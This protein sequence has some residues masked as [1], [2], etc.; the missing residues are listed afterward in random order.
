MPPRAVTLRV[1]TGLGPVTH[2]FLC[3]KPRQ[4]SLIGEKP[5]VTSG[6]GPATD[7]SAGLD[8]AA[9]GMAGRVPAIRPPTVRAQLAAIHPTP[10]TTRPMLTR[11]TP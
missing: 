5:A 1:M 2:D 6:R 9:S 4:P 8:P 3:T 7:P 10:T 11:A